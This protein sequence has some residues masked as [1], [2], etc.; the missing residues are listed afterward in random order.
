LQIRVET[1]AT[2][3]GRAAA[4]RDGSPSC[5]KSSLE[6]LTL[7]QAKAEQGRPIAILQTGDIR[8]GAPIPAALEIIRFSSP[9]ELGAAASAIRGVAAAGKTQIDAEFL[10]HLPKLEIV[11]SLGVGFDRVDMD[12]ARSAGIVVTNTPDVLTEE[13]A[14]LTLGL[15][16]ATV[17][18]IPAAE[19]FVRSGAWADGKQFPL[20]S[21]LRN[22]R[23]GIVGMG[24]IGRA[25]ARRCEAMLLPV[26]Y[27]GRAPKAGL[28][29]RY[30]ADLRELARDVNTLIVSVPANKQTKGLIDLQVLQ[31]LGADGVLINVAR[32]SVVDEPALIQCLQSR[33][34]LAAG[35]DVFADEPRVPAEL[36]SLEN[37]VLLPHVG[38]ASTVTREA[39]GDLVFANLDSWFAGR[40]P[41]TPV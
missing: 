1:G 23:I 26:S 38:S 3:T 31:A 35:L 24:R 16:I 8:I 28:T 33:T 13:V 34:I 25:V 21:S 7:D 4:G 2:A 32:G 39:M 10:R 5:R 15:L 37:A 14:D 36:L 29:N 20:S 11:A 12:A 40:G 19:R 27:F 9:A 18:A 30:Y 6:E 22:R 41:L 17:R